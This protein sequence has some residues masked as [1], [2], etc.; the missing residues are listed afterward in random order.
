MGGNVQDMIGL[1]KNKKIKAM[2]KTFLAA[3]KGLKLWGTI[4]QPLT[5]FLDETL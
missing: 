5:K 2:H 4:E 3:N 1:V